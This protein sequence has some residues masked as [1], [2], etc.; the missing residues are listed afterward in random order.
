VFLPLKSRRGEQVEEGVRVHPVQLSQEVE[1]ELVRM[2]RLFSI[3]PK[4]ATSRTM[5]E[6]IITIALTTTVVITTSLMQKKRK[7]KTRKN[8]LSLSL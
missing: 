2:F 5:K 7:K 6:S 4:M 3:F 8:Q 1:V